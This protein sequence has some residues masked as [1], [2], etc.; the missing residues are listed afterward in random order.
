[1]RRRGRVKSPT[2]KTD[3]WGTQVHFEVLRP[4]H[5]PKKIR[6]KIEYMHANPVKRGHVGTPG[7]WAWSSFVSYER[8]EGG[9][10]SIDFVD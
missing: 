3:V 2:R 7:E 10:V 1:V 8:G 4:G 5:P 6:E 9:L